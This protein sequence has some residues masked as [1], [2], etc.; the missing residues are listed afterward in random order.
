M[1]SYTTQLL[2]KICASWGS[3][4]RVL[5]LHE[6]L[7]LLYTLILTSLCARQYYYGHFNIRYLGSDRL[8]NLPKIIQLAKWINVGY[9]SRQSNSKV[10]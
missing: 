6:V 1:F 3:N 9:E 2:I 5:T 10:H 7:V 4:N 8:R